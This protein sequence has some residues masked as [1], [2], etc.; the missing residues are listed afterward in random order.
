[1][2]HVK[3]SELFDDKAGPYEEGMNGWSQICEN[4][5]TAHDIPRIMLDTDRGYGICGIEGCA[6]EADHYI[7]FPDWLFKD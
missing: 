7:D 1:M 4:C 5:V 3:Y 6:N 2:R